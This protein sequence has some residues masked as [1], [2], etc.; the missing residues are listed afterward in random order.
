[1]TNTHPASFKSMQDDY[2]ELLGSVPSTA[3]QRQRLAMA[4]GRFDALGAIESYRKELI[5]N[6]PLGRRTQQLVHLAM[7]IARGERDAATLHIAGA[8]KAGA[9]LLELQGVAETA[10]VVCGMPGYGLAVDLISQNIHV[11]DEM[12]AMPS[13]E[14]T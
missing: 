1:M 7:L 12:G 13:G 10:A 4:T 9:T 5:H 8:V 11:A 2:R 3:L 14:L 6:N